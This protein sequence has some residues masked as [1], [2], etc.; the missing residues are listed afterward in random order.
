MRRRSDGPDLAILEP[1]QI[2]VPAGW[3]MLD[4]GVGDKR[5]QPLHRLF[6]RGVRAER[7]GEDL[8]LGHYW[9]LAIVT[10]SPLG[11]PPIAAAIDRR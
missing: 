9:R 3:W 11:S 2:L 8:R 4:G 5:D 7:R 1:D 10:T 6:E